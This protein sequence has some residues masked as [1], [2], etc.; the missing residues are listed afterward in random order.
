MEVIRFLIKLAIGYFIIVGILPGFLLF[1]YLYMTY[2]Y[3]NGIGTYSQ[4]IAQDEADLK[5]HETSLADKYEMARK[6]AEE[7]CAS[8]FAYYVSKYQLKC[9]T[10]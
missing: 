9:G 1:G 5:W 3:T 8:H 2:Y 6:Q 10:K 7:H 4:Q